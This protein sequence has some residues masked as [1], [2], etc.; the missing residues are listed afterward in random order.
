MEKKNFAFKT[1]K[2]GETIFF[3][4]KKRKNNGATLR[5]TLES[6]H[7]RGYPGELDVAAVGGERSVEDPTAVGESLVRA[8]T[9]RVELAP[10]E[11]ATMPLALDR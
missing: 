11:P 6:R 9:V 7:P 3:A 2:N 1:K 10:G 8:A 4:Y 5:A